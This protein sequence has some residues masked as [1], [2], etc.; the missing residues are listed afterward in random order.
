MRNNIEKP[1]NESPPSILYHYT[2]QK[3][4]L[5]I[6]DKK[7]LWATNIYYLNDSLEYEYAVKL[8]HE[9]MSGYFDAL[10]P[11]RAIGRGIPPVLEEIPEIEKTNLERMMLESILGGISA[12]TSDFDVYVISFS[13]EGDQLSQWRGYCPNGNGFSLGFET[14]YLVN[15]MKKHSLRFVGCIYK[16]EEQVKILKEIIDK[17]IND[18]RSFL[19]KLENSKPEDTSK[20]IMGMIAPTIMELLYIMPRMKHE[21]FYEEKEWRFVGINKGSKHIHFREGKSM[22][23][24]YIKIPLVENQEPIKIDRIIVGPTPHHQLSQKSI[25]LL[26]DREKIKCKVESSKIPYRTW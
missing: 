14:S 9:V 19:D 22:I 13:Q 20:T 7:E 21:S 11:P 12:F 3:G 25:Q 24:P 2:S 26:M 4:L 17:S 5:E 23:I 1:D 10:P 6:I 18:F 15:I 8:I 16:K